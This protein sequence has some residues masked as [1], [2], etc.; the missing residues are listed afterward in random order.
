MD[1]IGLLN[2]TRSFIISCYDR[3]FKH[4]E[5]TYAGISEEEKERFLYSN[6]ICEAIRNDFDIASKEILTKL[7]ALEDSYGAEHSEVKKPIDIISRFEF[8]DSEI[9]YTV[10]K[11]NIPKEVVAYIMCYIV[12]LREGYDE[13][14]PK[15][16]PIDT[17]DVLKIISNINTKVGTSTEVYRNDTQCGVNYEDYVKAVYCYLYQEAYNRYKDRMSSAAKELYDIFSQPIVLLSTDERQELIDIY[18]TILNKELY[19]RCE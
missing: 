11:Y 17:D 9:R 19:V 2:E 3:V 13:D 1:K 8:L 15:D 12:G 16:I 6:Y 5:S 18:G 14:L 10:R 7:H 4:I